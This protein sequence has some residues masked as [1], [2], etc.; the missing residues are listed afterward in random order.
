M[1]RLDSWVPN[2]LAISMASLMATLGGTSGRH[3]SS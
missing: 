1:N 2:F 3:R